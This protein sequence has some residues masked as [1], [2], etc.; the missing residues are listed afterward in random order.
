MIP[1]GSVIKLFIYLL[2]LAQSNSI[3]NNHKAS[4]RQKSKATSCLVPIKTIA[5]L[6]RTQ[7]NTQQNM[8]QS[9]SPTMGATINGGT[10]ITE[11]PP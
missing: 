7:N 3:N 5:K 8:E 11:L 10:V 6:E 2:L 9:Q 1:C 4:G